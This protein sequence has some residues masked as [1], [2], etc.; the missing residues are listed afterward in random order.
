MYVGIIAGHLFLYTSLIPNIIGIFLIMWTQALDGA[1]GQLARMTQNFS[2]LGRILD[3]FTGNIIFV[4]IY[5]HISLRAMF[6]GDNGWVW[7]AAFAAGLSHSIQSAMA[8]FYRNG[9]LKFA[10]S[11]KKG[12]LEHSSEIKPRYAQLSWKENFWEKFLMRVYLNYTIEQ[13]LFSPSFVAL[14][15]KV[16]NEYN[17]MIPEDCS[18]EY[19]RLSRPMIKYYNMLTTN[20]RLTVLFIAVLLNEVYLYFAF[21]LTVLNLMLIYTVYRQEKISRIMLDKIENRQ[22]ADVGYLGSGN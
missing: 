8:D 18:R 22:S 11:P 21:D 3:G 15:E 4:S 2:K 1:D 9:F 14:K 16:M 10:I 17:G 7:L 6:M 19:Y 13:E 20:T 5:I 12:E